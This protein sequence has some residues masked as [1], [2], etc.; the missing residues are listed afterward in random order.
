MLVAAAQEF[1][2]R[3]Y[4]GASYAGVA[5]RAGV[6][7]SRVQYYAATKAELAAL[8]AR[9]AFTGAALAADHVA[10]ETQGIEAVLASVAQVARATEHDPFTRAAG[11][12]TVE[13]QGAGL[14][15]PTPYV[16]WIAR[17][18]THLDEA[19]RAGELPA[20][21]DTPAEA[22]RLVAAFTGVKSVLAVLEPPGVSLAEEAG[23]VIARLLDA[24]RATGRGTDRQ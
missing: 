4:A 3:G 1:A 21:I 9:R 22:R 5:A 11:R 6:G 18:T 12:L 15:L 14:D 8:V 2:E 19:V 17:I 10:V 24:L 7:K 20:S 23:L 13:A 16:G